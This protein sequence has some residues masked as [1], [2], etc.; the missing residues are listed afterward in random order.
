[1]LG[2]RA[3]KE[4][5]TVIPT[6]IQFPGYRHTSVLLGQFSK[7]V[8]L[9][10]RRGGFPLLEAFPAIYGTSLR[11][12]KWHRSFPVT[13]RADGFCLYPLVIAPALR[14][15]ECLCALGFAVFAALRLVFELFVVEEELFAGSENKIGPTIYT[16]ENLILELHCDAPF[17]DHSGARAHR[18][19]KT[20]PSDFKVAAYCWFGPVTK[21]SS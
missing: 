12:L 1:M 16:L 11:W 15:A 20:D 6:Q 4:I 13:C 10:S 8:E 7:N 17:P 19:G 9:C 5:G 18:T 21:K 2:R 3:F 14:Q